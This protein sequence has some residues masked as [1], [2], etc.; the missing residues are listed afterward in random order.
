MVWWAKEWGFFIR[1]P[2]E[3]IAF[4]INK[5]V[6]MNI[7]C[8]SKPI[9]VLGFS[10]PICPLLWWACP[11]PRERRGNFHSPHS[12]CHKV[13]HLPHLTLKSH[14]PMLITWGYPGY[15]AFWDTVKHMLFQWLNSRTDPP[16]DMMCVEETDGTKLQSTMWLC[17]RM[18][19][20]YIYAVYV[21]IY[22]AFQFTGPPLLARDCSLP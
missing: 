5:Q 3:A 1:N 13:R 11:L 12:P 7:S 2:Q 8:T 15:P 22:K 16:R 21:Y 14:N 17:P 20:I 6:N 9:Q 19:Y 18:G 4:T 10:C